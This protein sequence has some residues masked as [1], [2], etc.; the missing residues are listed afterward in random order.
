M[1]ADT[2]R[3][4][5][6]TIEQPEALNLDVEALLTGFLRALLEEQQAKEAA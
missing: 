4:Q 3:L 6:E 2:T 5:G 1:A